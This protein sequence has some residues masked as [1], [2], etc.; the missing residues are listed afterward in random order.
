MNSYF[1]GLQSLIIT[2]R[3]NLFSSFA[4]TI[5]IILLIIVW[6]ARGNITTFLE[7][8]PSPEMEQKRFDK[9]LVADGLIN[10]ALEVDRIKINADRVM[11]RQ[12]HNSK[13]DLTGLPF[14][15][16]STT[17]AAMAPGV[18]LEPGSMD[19]APLST[20][21]SQLSKMWTG[22][23][24]PKCTR[25]EK[26]EVKSPQYLE[27]WEKNGVAIAF[28]CPLLNLR[29]QPVGIIGAGYMVSEKKRPTDDKIF[30]ILNK[31][32]EKA[33]GYLD[34]VTM[35]ERKPWYRRILGE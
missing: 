18:T 25:M 31:T 33:V 29:G 21:N 27:Y 24:N 5:M 11:I 28:S 35:A 22:D 32:G 6:S 4:T 9:A 1:A 17:Y 10:D 14:A 13:A 2:V 34:A 20:M 16:I 7:R 19:P 12:F 23:G 15:S 30:E 8:N 3:R 26:I